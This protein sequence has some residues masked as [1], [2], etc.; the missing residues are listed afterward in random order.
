MAGN[1][2]GLQQLVQQAKA[3]NQG[4]GKNITF[5]PGVGPK[6]IHA[7]EGASAA[8]ETIV[9]NAGQLKVQQ[10]EF[11]NIS[12]FAGQELKGMFV[13]EKKRLVDGLEDLGVAFER[14]QDLFF[15][16]SK[17][18]QRTEADSAN[19]FKFEDSVL[20]DN[21]KAYRYDSKE[22]SDLVEGRRFASSDIGAS[23]DILKDKPE[24]GVEVR[25]VKDA[26]L[27]PP[28]DAMMPVPLAQLADTINHAPLEAD[29][30]LW[31]SMSQQMTKLAGQFT[32]DMNGALKFWEGRGQQGAVEAIE[33]YIAHMKGLTRSMTSMG[34]VLAYT[35]GWLWATWKNMPATGEP[36]DT[37]RSGRTRE[38]VYETNGGDG[39][40]RGG[41]SV[42][43]SLSVIRIDYENLYR[44]PMA[45]SWVPVV[46]EYR[47]KPGAGPQKPGDQDPKNSPGD[48][49]NPAPGANPGGNPGAGPT[50]G[51]AAPPQP[52]NPG[53]TGQNEKLD[54]AFGNVDTAAKDLQK[55]LDKIEQGATQIQKG[56]T[57]IGDGAQL[58]AQGNQL[59]QQAAQMRAAGRI[60]EADALTAQ[61]QRL[62]TQGREKVDDG[63]KL[64]TAGQRDMKTG[65]AETKK[66]AKELARAEKA[67]REAGKDLPAEQRKSVDQAVDNA[68]KFRGSTV[69]QAEKLTEDYIDAGDQLLKDSKDLLD[70]PDRTEPAATAIPGS[71]ADPAAT[72]APGATAD[73]AAPLAQ[74]APTADP[75]ATP[76][77]PP[78]AQPAAAV[79]NP[80]DLGL[81]NTAPGTTPVAAPTDPGLTN[82][83]ATPANP[84]A[85]PQAG[86]VT[87]GTGQNP[88]SQLAGVAQQV[89]SFVQQAGQ[90]LTNL[91]QAGAIPN[92]PLPAVPDIPAA[93]RDLGGGAPPGGLGGG[94]G[95]P[96]AG[97]AGVPTGQPL[98]PAR[99]FG[100]NIPVQTST[101]ATG[102]EPRAGVPLGAQQPM[103]GSPG[104]PGAGAGAGQGGQDGEH[105]RPKFLQST[106][107][108]EE[109]LGEAPAVYKAVIDR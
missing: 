54:K 64:V 71:A 38:K 69:E 8:L 109:A 70:N 102:V 51:P 57:A 16:T 106:E 77:A 18:Y 46:P 89:G 62:I 27:L 88:L 72:P 84:T 78:A 9:R 105:K 92:M 40:E 41:R 107:H 50:A 42:Q 91:I 108:L 2:D 94:G 47:R 20:D 79:P 83:A 29:S 45:A 34:E 90:G 98:A 3:A 103:M 43:K 12:G 55:N 73:P 56:Q 101:Q 21:K 13:E 32:E 24:S 95:A 85:T 75:G 65:L 22:L 31:F 86:P 49:E 63:R 67:L 19:G 25:N 4:S 28:K 59:K 37:S 81:Q 76:G 96:G 15:F 30:R 53:P 36:V 68:E 14:M 58:I 104:A 93:L 87:P 5:D 26:S 100:P 74:P 97:P 39:G 10:A 23:G 99:E 80:G 61:G 48:K 82:P 1:R 35:A 33:S 52:T 7:L 44:K 66:D 17:E 11:G 6:A 60:Q